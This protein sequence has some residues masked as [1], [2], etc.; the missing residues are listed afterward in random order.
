MRLWSVGCLLAVVVSVGTTVAAPQQVVR[1]VEP[2]T[3]TIDEMFQRADVVAKVEIT[4]GDAEHYR[5]ALDK[6][7]VIEGF[8]GTKAGESLYFGPFIG[9]RLGDEYLLFVSREKRT[10]GESVAP[11]QVNATGFDARAPV[12]RITQE[13]Y[14]ALETAFFL[15]RFRLSA[16]RAKLRLDDFQ[17]RAKLPQ[18]FETLC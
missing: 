14:S 4:L 1:N 16:L 9:Y 7:T 2:A 11:G 18:L 10:V 17:I 8:K 6:S 13:G 15:F 12:F 3:L 5:Q